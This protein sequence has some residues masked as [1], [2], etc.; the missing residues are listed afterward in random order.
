M[1]KKINV[2]GHTYI[3]EPKKATNP[4]FERYNIKEEVNLHKRLTTMIGTPSNCISEEVA[5]SR[6]ICVMDPANVLMIIS[7]TN[8]AKLI[9]R[10]YVEQEDAVAKIPNL[11]YK[12]KK[13]NKESKSRYSMSYLTSAILFFKVQST[14][15][16]IAVKGEYPICLENE[17]FKIII[18]PRSVE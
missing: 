5:L 2:D 7:K 16:D 14:S 9:L 4:E 3:L 8:R 13:S 18:A 15:I 6:D 17:D 11:D 10:R 1:K 12:P